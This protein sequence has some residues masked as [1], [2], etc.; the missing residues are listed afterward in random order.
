MSYTPHGKGKPRPAQDE[1]KT[2]SPF[3]SFPEPRG[4]SGNWVGEALYQK[5]QSTPNPNKPNRA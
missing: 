5:T 4:W 2:E 3:E 1:E